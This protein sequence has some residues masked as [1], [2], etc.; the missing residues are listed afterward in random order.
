M[1]TPHSFAWSMWVFVCV[2][3][4][5]LVCVVFHTPANRL[6]NLMAKFR[7]ARDRW[8]S[9]KHTVRGE[10]NLEIL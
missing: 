2:R 8:E 3:A 5:L 9:G 6:I 10:I 1:A 7:W 4:R